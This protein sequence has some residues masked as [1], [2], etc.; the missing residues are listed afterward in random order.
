MNNFAH[1]HNYH[2][3]HELIVSF[4]ISYVKVLTWRWDWAPCQMLHCL[5]ICLKNLRAKAQPENKRDWILCSS[6]LSYTFTLYPQISSHIS[7]SH[8]CAIRLSVRLFHESCFLGVTL[9][10]NSVSKKRRK[11]SCLCDIHGGLCGSCSVQG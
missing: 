3:N 2:V 9:F 4:K 1:F 7:S 5:L 6:L 8:V 10:V 11:Y